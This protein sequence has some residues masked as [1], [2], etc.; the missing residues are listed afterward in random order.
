LPSFSFF[1][2]IARDL[3]RHVGKANAHVLDLC[4]G[5]G[6]ST[7]ALQS[8]FEDAASIIAV[9]TSKEMIEMAKML[10]CKSFWEY[11]MAKWF[12]ANSNSKQDDDDY[13]KSIPKYAIGNAENTSL[14]NEAFD[15]VTIMYAF[16]EAPH[17]GRYRILR[18]ARRVLR[19]GATLCVMDI[20]PSFEPSP[21]MLAGE[22]YVLEYKKN[23]QKQL[24]KIQGFTDLVYKEVVPGHVGLWLLTRARNKILSDKS[25]V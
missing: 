24:E 21:T 16:H 19:D 3:R 1:L 10:N 15:L 9:D 4:C 13:K 22:P 11:V 20:A 5:V 23:I 2:Q 8:A 25:V 18:E 6:M 12:S 17:H 14:P 7:R